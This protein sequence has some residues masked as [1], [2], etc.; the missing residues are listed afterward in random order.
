[1]LFVEPVF[2]ALAALFTGLAAIPM[3]SGHFKLVLAATSIIFLALSLDPA[4]LWL[5]AGFVATGFMATL[6]ARRFGWYGAVPGLIVLLAEFV[7]VHAGGILLVDPDLMGIVGILGLAYVLS[8]MIHILVDVAVDPKGMPRVTGLDYLNVNLSF[9]TF[10]SG[11]LQR[12]PDHLDAIERRAPAQGGARVAA[13]GR[14]ATGYAKILIAL[15]LIDLAQ[16]WLMKQAADGTVIGV[17]LAA[18]AGVAVG[19]DGPALVTITF[20]VLAATLFPIRLYLNFAAYMD[21]V[22]GLGRLAGLSLPENFRHPF[23]ANALLDY[24]SRWHITMS[25]W[26]RDYIFTPIVTA[27]CRRWPSAR[28]MEVHAMIGLLVTF[29]VVGLWHD[30]S[31]GFVAIGLLIGAGMI[32]NRAWRWGLKSALGSSAWT[33]LKGRSWY[34]AGS[35]VACYLFLTSFVAIYMWLYGDAPPP[36][37]APRPV[38]LLV[39]LPVVPAIFLGGLVWR[40]L[41]IRAEGLTARI[42]A[43]WRSCLGL[44]AAICVLLLIASIRTDVIPEFAYARF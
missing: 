41:S 42:D 27:L 38:F 12:F 13:L 5:L 4:R 3:R 24:W 6:A 20:Q 23:R 18:M 25:D 1:M 7:A 33:R 44:A 9:L 36:A 21:I 19:R 2:L 37:L 31:L 14:I 32:W 8:R 43:D 35:A 16:D 11:P 28:A 15:P 34:R 29:V 22:I 10:L 39:L 40:H 26:Y 30:V 17:D